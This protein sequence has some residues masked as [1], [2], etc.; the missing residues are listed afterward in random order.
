M[1]DGEKLKATLENI[2]ITDKGL[3]SVWGSKITRIQLTGTTVDREEE[4]KIR[5]VLQ[6][7]IN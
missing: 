4:W 7:R 6:R 3:Q 2:P 1:Y 5:F